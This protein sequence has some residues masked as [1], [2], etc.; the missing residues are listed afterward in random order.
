MG[1]VYFSPLHCPPTYLL[2]CKKKLIYF[3]IENENYRG[4]FSKP[5]YV[6][7]LSRMILFVFQINRSKYFTGF[8]SQYVKIYRKIYFIYFLFSRNLVFNTLSICC[9]S[10]VGDLWLQKRTLLPVESTEHNKSL[11]HTKISISLH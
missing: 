3:F 11:F 4:L 8:Q 5:E 7:S 2:L 10:S 1:K 6:A 9:C